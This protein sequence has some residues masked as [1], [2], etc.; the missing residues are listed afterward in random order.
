MF[1]VLLTLTVIAAVGVVFL[2]VGND[3][4]RAVSGPAVV[5]LWDGSQAR[6][7]TSVHR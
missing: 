5:A 6:A 2:L 1:W 3:P 7:R 4:L